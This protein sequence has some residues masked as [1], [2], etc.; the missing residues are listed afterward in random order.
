M[1]LLNIVS[2]PRGAQSASIAV[3]NA[4]L[5]AYLKTSAS[6]EV[7]T[8]NVWDENL[9][10][11]DSQAIGAKYK[12][13]SKEPM[14]EAESS[15]WMRIQSLVKRFQEADRIVVGVPMWNFGYPYK[16]KQLIDLV[17][18][19]NML[20]TFDGDAYGPMLKIPRALVICVRGQSHDKGAGVMSPGFTFQA[21]YIDF[22]LKFIGVKEVETLL[23]EHTWDAKAQETVEQGKAQ[24]AAMAAHF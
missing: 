14:D 8:L 5:D 9:P 10:D 12:G 20:F 22:W 18:Q 17:S 24:A 2:S 23:V 11:F 4:F 6:I 19:R 13:V 16:L 7:D 15:I 21:D 1:R 3:A